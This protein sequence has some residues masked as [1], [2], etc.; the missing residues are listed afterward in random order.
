M[1]PV[2]DSSGSPHPAT[3]GLAIRR[4]SWAGT[5]AFV[6]SAVAA[7]LSPSLARVALLVAGILFAAGCAVFFWAF[8]VMAGRSRTVRLELAQVWFLAGPP[9]PGPVRRSLLG[10]LAVQVVAALVTAGARPYTSL[11]AGVL[12]P[13]YGLALCGLWGAR[14]GVFPPLE[15]QRS[16]RGGVRSGDAD[17]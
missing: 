10:A 12:V 5:V 4:A 11:A 14:H 9:I 8:L 17:Q 15:P 13:M 6:A 2:A 3:D 1:I 7:D 16:G